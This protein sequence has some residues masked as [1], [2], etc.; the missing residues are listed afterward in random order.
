M[1]LGLDKGWGSFATERIGSVQLQCMGPGGG[2]CRQKCSGYPS[3]IVSPYNPRLKFLMSATG[4]SASW[5]SATRRCS[6]TEDI[7]ELANGLVGNRF[8]YT[9]YN[10]RDCHNAMSHCI[11]HNSSKKKVVSGKVPSDHGSAMSVV[12]PACWPRSVVALAGG[13]AGSLDTK[14]LQQLGTERVANL[15]GGGTRIRAIVEDGGRNI[16]VACFLGVLRVTLHPW[17]LYKMVG[18][19]V[20]VGGGGGGLVITRTLM[21]WQNEM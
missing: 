5:L 13:G 10:R 18:A 9:A 15:L 21:V 2:N 7:I 20:C 8:F 3:V 12:S 11:C 17:S 14:H 4:M 1:T 16:A 19:Q 6:G